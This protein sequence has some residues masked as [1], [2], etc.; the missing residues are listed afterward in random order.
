MDVE[1]ELTSQ[2]AEQQEALAG[3]QAALEAAGGDSEELQQVH[4]RAVG[5][6]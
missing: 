1:D 6:S 5:P 3:V 2:L 4:M